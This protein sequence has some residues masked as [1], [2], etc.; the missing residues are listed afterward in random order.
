LS[1]SVLVVEDDTLV[2]RAYE[3]VLAPEYRVTSVGTGDD[4][5]S[6][7]KT[8]QF[9]AIVSDID[10][11][12]LSGIDLLKAVRSTDLDVPVVLVTGCPSLE[13]A[14]DAVNF[15]AFSYLTKP[16]TPA[17]LRDVVTRATRVH[18]LLALQRMA[19]GVLGRTADRI[20]DRAGLEVRF[21]SALSSLWMAFQPIVSTRLG[22]TV[23]YEALLRTDEVSLR[24]P[25]DLLGAA[26][27]LGRLGELGRT[28]RR[29]IADMLPSAPPDARIF[30]NLHAYDLA[31]DEIYDPKSVLAPFASRIVLE[32][33]ERAS[34][35]DVDDL[36]ER[37]A[38]LRSL[39][40]K[41]AIDDLGAG[42]AGL[43][44]LTK[45]EPEVVKLDMSLVRGVDESHTKQQLVASMC[46]VCRDLGMEVVT[47]GVETPAERDALVTLGCDLLQGYL[48]G[49]P[50]RQFVP[51]AISR[52]EQRSER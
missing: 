29:R 20:S 38:K 35:D 31:D 41:L 23:G 11:P 43:T 19:D 40:F 32:V 4:A 12:G 36:A 44:S 28:V 15:G 37:V 16:V 34:L 7:L 2:R 50:Q 18:G 49:R 39:G 51:G 47:E 5:L 9:T 22:K 52:P 3:R 24:S 30:I 25:P 10:M 1:S 45:L 13:S 42:Y 21:E 14:Q 46:Q 26:E 33:T 48:F 27:K 6:E 8:G 17:A